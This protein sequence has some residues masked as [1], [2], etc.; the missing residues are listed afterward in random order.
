MFDYN[1]SELIHVEQKEY[2]IYG[3]T[4]IVEFGI[5]LNKE[6]EEIFRYALLEESYLDHKEINSKVTLTKT[7]ELILTALDE[8]KTILT[9]RTKEG[10]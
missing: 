2:L 9:E 1:N 10:V 7:K 4:Y 6:N 5:Y 8:R 3:N